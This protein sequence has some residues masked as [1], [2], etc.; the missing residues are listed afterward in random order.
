MKPTTERLAEALEADGAPDEMIERARTGYYDDFKSRLAMP[1]MQLVAD[2]RHEG[3]HA[4]AKF[5]MEGEFDST[6]DEAEEW[7]RSEEGT[8]VRSELLG[9]KGGGKW[10]G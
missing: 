10:R 1:I 5:A 2:C 3:L 8:V 6:R 9:K 7:A 4:I